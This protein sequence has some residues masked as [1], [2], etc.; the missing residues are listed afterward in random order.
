MVSELKDF[1]P[2]D[3]GQEINVTTLK[4]SGFNYHV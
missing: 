1:T 4:E 2:E 3:R